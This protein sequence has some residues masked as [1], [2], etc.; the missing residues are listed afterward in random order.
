MAPQPRKITR[1]DPRRIVIEWDGGEVTELSAAELR[2]LC[3]CAACVDEWTNQRTLDPGSVSEALTLLEVAP[4]GNYALR[5]TFSD[6]HATGIYPW[7][8]LREVTERAPAPS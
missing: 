3:P 7:R 8:V 4:V 1:S 2:T 6:R 5:I